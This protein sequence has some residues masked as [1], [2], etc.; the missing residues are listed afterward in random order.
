MSEIAGLVRQLIDAGTPPDVAAIV[1]AEAFAAGAAYRRPEMRAK[2]KS[3]PEIVR[4]GIYIRDGFVCAYCGNCD[5]PFHIDHIHPVAKGGTNDPKNLT[6]ACVHCN[7][8]KGA[9]PLHEWKQ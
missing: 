4:D 6:I 2:R 9:K 8:S 7:I 3:I 1:V 5:G